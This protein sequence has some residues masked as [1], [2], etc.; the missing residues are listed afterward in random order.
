MLWD[1]RCREA[2]TTLEKTVHGNDTREL[3]ETHIKG[4]GERMKGILILFCAA[5]LIFGSLWGGAYFM[6]IYPQGTWQGFP[7]FFTA[8]AL[9]AAGVVLAIH[10]LVEMKL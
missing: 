2:K 7:V 4:S 9:F 10:A 1:A 8:L 5:V 3:Q 6:H